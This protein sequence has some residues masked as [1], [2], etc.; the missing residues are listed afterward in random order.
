MIRIGMDAWNLP[1]DQRGIGRYVRSVLAVWATSAADRVSVTLVIPERITLFAAKRYRDEL[2]GSHHYASSSRSRLVAAKLDVLWFPFN[3]VSWNDNFPGPAVATLH[4]ASTFVLPDYGDDARAPFRMAAARCARLLTDSQ[5]SADELARELA[6]PRD[7]LT[8]VPLGVAP[9][10]HASPSPAVDPKLYGR[11]VLYVGGTE[12][13]KN[14]KTAFAAMRR[15][16]ERDAELMLVLI[17]PMPFTLPPHEN[18]RVAALGHVDDDTLTAFYRACVAFIYP[19]TYEGFGLPILEAMS[20]GA[21]VVAARSSSL[22][23]VGGDAALYVDPYDDLGFADAIMALLE[24]PALSAALRERGQARAAEMTW[25]H[26]A[27]ATLRVIEDVVA[28][29][30]AAN[31]ESD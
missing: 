20:Y 21:P 17:G 8:T 5:F 22:P 15:L 4:D 23:E 16:T 26:T 12:S 7:R 19:S 30:R 6:I 11:F 31:G 2:P 1:G 24:R 25:E 3:G 18:V 10:R 28:T 27:E 13:R 14:L 29:A 9:A